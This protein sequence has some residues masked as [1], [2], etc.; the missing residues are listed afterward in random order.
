MLLLVIHN[1]ER[2]Y[3]LYINCNPWQHTGDT[4]MYCTSLRSPSFFKENYNIKAHFET[5][6]VSQTKKIKTSLE[7]K[8][9]L[10]ER[11]KRIKENLKIL[12]GS[13]LKIR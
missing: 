4:F 13:N 5:Q 12:D 11:Q 10:E 7:R 9:S 6:N 3:I 2:S 1:I 8:T